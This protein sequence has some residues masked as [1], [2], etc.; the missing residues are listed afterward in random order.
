MTLNGDEAKD[1]LRKAFSHVLERVRPVRAM[2]RGVPLVSAALA[3]RQRRGGTV[4]PARIVA[5][6][7]AGLPMLDALLSS[8]GLPPVTGVVA[9]PNPDDRQRP[10]IQV[11]HGGHPLPNRASLQAAGVALELVRDASEEDLVLYLVSGGGSAA[12]EL[13][14]RSEVSLEDL[15][16]AYGILG[17]CGAR[18]TEVNTVRKHLS[19]VKGGRLARVAAPS[20]QITLYISDVPRGRD[21]SV[22]SGPTM[23]DESTIEDAYRMAAR[24][25]LLE[26][27]PAS[28]ARTLRD[29]ALEETPKPG[30]VIFDRSEW[31]CLLSSED[32][33][34]AAADYARTSGWSYVVSGSVEDLSVEEAA[35]SLLAQLAALR[36]Q[37][38]SAAAVC[39]IVAGELRSPVRGPGA[40]GRSQSFVLECVSRIAGRRIA[41]LSAG[42]DGIDGNSTAAGAVADGGSLS[43]GRAA[44]LDAARHLADSDSNAY[45]RALGDDVVTGP[46]G[47]NVRDLMILLEW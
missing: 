30:D 35:A 42:T 15:A 2:E 16:G 14:L 6:G 46:T 43:R 41:V 40:G 44:G 36:S 20:R 31:H 17:S 23:P 8:V 19:A 4:R 11:F 21:S 25:E 29:R 26:R 45:F 32:A 34:E 22:A 24:H 27:L 28:I 9:T 10:G 13:P 38:A 18:I 12:L 1:E 7:K 5:L 39:V 37:A 3:D 33:V 47:T